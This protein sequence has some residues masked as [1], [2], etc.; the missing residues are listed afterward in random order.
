MICPTHIWRTFVL[1]LTLLPSIL[2]AQSK[3]DSLLN[4]FQTSGANDS[5]CNEL[6]WAYVFNAPD[7]AIFFG[8][9][10]LEWVNDKNSPRLKAK[11]LNR[12]GVAYDIKSN[13]DSALYFYNLA[14]VVAREIG[15]RKSEGGALNNIGLIYWNLGKA[16]KAID[17]YIRSAEIFDE[18]GNKVGLGNTYNNIALILY[19]DDQLEKCERYHKQ[20]LQIRKE[21][22]HEYGIAASYS[23]LAQL[24]STKGIFKMDTAI[25][26]LEL[27]IPI[28][29]K[30]NDQYGL[31]RSYHNL[32]DIYMEI[33]RLGESLE[34]HGKALRIQLDLGNSEGYAS[35]YYN[36][37]AV[38]EKLGDRKTKLIYLDSAEQAA[39]KH[40]D[41]SLLWK[42]FRTKAKTLG[43]LKR[44]D[45][46]NQ[47]WLYY[48][49]LK[50]SIVNLERS[51]QVEELET[52]YRTAEQKKEIADKKSDLAEAKLK[53]ENRN[54]W[55]FGLTGGLASILLLAFA[56]FQNYRR[57]TQAEKDAA[58]I[59]ER[60]RGLKAMIEATEEERKRIAKDLHDGIVQSL[61]GLSL[62][63]QKG[64]SFLKSISEKDQQEFEGS[65]KMLDESI[66]E[67]RTISHQMMPR[68]LSEMGLI[69]AL[70][71][72]LGKSLGN[73]NIQY[74][75][76]HHKV[77]G[78]RFAENMEVSLYRI[79]QEL[80][81]NIIKH[82]EAK[83]VSVQLLKTKT[84]LVLV[85]EDNGK[86][87]NFDDDNN[88]NGIGLMN[89]SSRAKAING[90]VN[91]QPS[92]EQGTVATIRIPLR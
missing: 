27:A 18:I 61:T 14:M 39:S 46:A 30:L 58:I 50:D 54:K 67:L 56:L 19:E 60:E 1:V 91:Y 12:I 29:Q 80:V 43:K 35:T 33:G 69:P 38:Y 31:A 32:G 20:A 76:E 59:A 2:L 66:A 63:L 22:N 15:D 72:M 77:E 51:K 92:P 36:I 88:L 53:L 90:E 26:Y 34:N 70:D 17:H 62:R 13:P 10:G 81:N 40:E 79:C 7:S 75:F 6:I 8:K 89:I 3:K 42:V 84:H 65:R 23:N 5:L 47:Y 28:K 73:T 57:K 21:I 49:N 87:F 83:A 41:L 64:F 37:S 85:V 74:E 11:M 86:G 16:D 24:Y 68:V 48:D 52:K 25:H 44:F 9:R 55:I 82:S 45:E 71:D 4:V 78:E